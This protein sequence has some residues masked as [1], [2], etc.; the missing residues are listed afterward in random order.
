MLKISI[1]VCF[2]DYFKDHKSMFLDHFNGKMAAVFSYFL[3][4]AAYEEKNC[5]TSL[6]L[7]D[8]LS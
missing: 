4:M 2:E 1:K 5:L 8:I 7:S 6:S 3:Q